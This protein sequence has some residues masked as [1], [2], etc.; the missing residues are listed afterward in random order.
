MK[1]FNL[2][3]ING[4]GY[5]E[6]KPSGINKGAFASY[7]LREEIIKKRGPDF[8]LCIGDDTSD[9]EMFKFFK[10]KKNQIKNY[11]KVIKTIVISCLIYIKEN[12]FMNIKNLK[13]FLISFNDLL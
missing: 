12:P 8:I 11:I 4:K 2:N 9:E 5:V 13:F 7:I 1:N 10:R 3:I 6:V